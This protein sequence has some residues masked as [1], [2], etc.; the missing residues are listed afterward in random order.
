MT[1]RIFYPYYFENDSPVEYLFNEALLNDVPIQN[2]KITET[3]LL[4]FFPEIGS[5]KLTKH[6]ISIMHTLVSTNY[7]RFDENQKYLPFFTKEQRDRLCVLHDFFNIVNAVFINFGESLTREEYVRNQL[8]K[9]RIERIFLPIRSVRHTYYFNEMA[10]EQVKECE[11]D[12]DKVYTTLVSFV[13]SKNFFIIDELFVRL[14]E[15]TIINHV[16]YYTNGGVDVFYRKALFDFVASNKHSIL[17]KLERFHRFEFKSCASN[18][19]YLNFRHEQ[20]FSSDTD[21]QMLSENVCVNIFL[22]DFNVRRINGIDWRVI[23]IGLPCLKG[24]T[25]HNERDLKVADLIPIK[26]ICVER[27]LPSIEKWFGCEVEYRFKPN[28]DGYLTDVWF[29]SKT[30]IPYVNHTIEINDKKVCKLL[31]KKSDKKFGLIVEFV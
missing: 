7:E 28:R 1:E 21:K 29:V 12:N 27:I 18:W 3:Q 8:T 5:T 23:Q 26:R 25:L 6:D 20:Y 16:D 14:I 30:C 24:Y 9:N 17:K 11:D 10:E 4:S 19:C 2:P 15:E 31:Q 13:Q 22:D